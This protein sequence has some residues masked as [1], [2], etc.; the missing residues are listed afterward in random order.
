MARAQGG[1]RAA[2]QR[3]RVVH[4][5]EN[6]DE[7]R[8]DA[9]SIAAGND[10]EPVG[11]A[12]GG[13]MRAREVHEERRPRVRG[14]IEELRRG[15]CRERARRALRRR[16][17]RGNAARDEHAPVGQR[18]R[19]V[20]RSCDAQT[21]RRARRPGGVYDFRRREQPGRVL[22]AGHQHAAVAERRRGR[23]AP[24]LDER[25]DHLPRAHGLRVGRRDHHHGQSGRHRDSE[26][27][28]RHRAC[29]P[30]RHQT[31]PTLPCSCAHTDHHAG[32]AA[33]I[34]AARCGVKRGDE[35]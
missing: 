3:K 26:H 5:I 15:R 22:S 29:H 12:R 9:V 20:S 17:A 24:H 32:N 34:S 25:S 7:P 35:S 27:E 2:R 16:R 21:A 18:R 28:R 11:G 6:F 31:T 10:D 8:R 14:R 30:T 19:R 1:K 33:Q 13:V 23:A 4:R